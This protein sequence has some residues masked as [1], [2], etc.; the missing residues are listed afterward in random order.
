MRKLMLILA[1]I[2]GLVVGFTNEV[3]AHDEVSEMSYMT[4]NELKMFD[5]MIYEIYLEE[6]CTNLCEECDFYYY[7]ECMCN[8]C[9][10]DCEDCLSYDYEIFVDDHYDMIMDYYEEV[11]RDIIDSRNNPKVEVKICEF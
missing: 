3:D 5:E 10:D 6:Y 8:A 1:M 11:L 4:H 7:A 9:Y 2:V